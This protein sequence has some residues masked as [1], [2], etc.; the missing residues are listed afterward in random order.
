MQAG[1]ESLVGMRS[2]QP[3]QCS[4]H[5]HRQDPLFPFSVP[6]SPEQGAPALAKVADW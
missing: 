4:G 1:L 2:T 3:I 6:L 5:N